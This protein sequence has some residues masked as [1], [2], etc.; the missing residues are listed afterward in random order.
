MCVCVCVTCVLPGLGVAVK[1]PDPI[2]RLRQLVDSIHVATAVAPL[3]LPAPSRHY[4]TPSV[5]VPPRQP[6]QQVELE[7]HGTCTGAWKED[8]QVKHEPVET[9]QTLRFV[10]RVSDTYLE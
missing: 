4:G 1:Q 10:F 9:G 5:L 8:I 7:V 3:L 6:F 2:Q